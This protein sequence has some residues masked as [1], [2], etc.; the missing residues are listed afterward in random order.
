MS[1][2][3]ARCLNGESLQATRHVWLFRCHSALGRLS[4]ATFFLGLAV[5]LL[6]ACFAL[7]L[8][9]IGS[10]KF[11]FQGSRCEQSTLTI[12][13]VS[14]MKQG[15]HSSFL[16]APASKDEQICAA[17]SKLPCRSQASRSVTLGAA[18]ADTGMSVPA[19][20]LQ[21][22]Q[23][24]KDSSQHTANPNR[25]AEPDCTVNLIGL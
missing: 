16:C 14:A 10:Q 19:V 12:R 2:N 22:R 17:L 18:G 6:T 5:D 9:E 11:R 25:S 15:K 7:T 4:R 20:L 24:H 3:S 13:Q 8:G 23:G 21:V 1:A